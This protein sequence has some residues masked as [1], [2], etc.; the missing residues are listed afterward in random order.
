[1]N[2]RLEQNALAEAGLGEPFEILCECAREDCTERISIRPLDYER[3]RASA[4]EF[5]IARGHH[6]ATLERIV[7]ATKGY[8]IVEKFGEAAAVAVAQ[9]PRS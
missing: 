5:V 6:D 3:V 2:E 9:D 1:M 4:T 8:E 7:Q